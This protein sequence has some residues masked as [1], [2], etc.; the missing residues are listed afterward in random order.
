M[1]K[2]MKI[3]NLSSASAVVMWLF[4]CIALGA[5]PIKVACVGN[6]VTFGAGIENVEERYPSQLQKLLGDGYQVRNFGHNGATLLNNGHRPYQSL[7]EFEEAI[8]FNADIVIIH[9]GLNDTDPRNWPFYRDEFVKNYIGLIDSFKFANPD[10]E[11][12][13]CRLTPIFPQHPRFKSSTRDWYWQIQDAIETVA[14]VRKVELVDLH[15]PLHRRPDLFP[16]A[17][18][19]SSEG[20]EIIAKTIYGVITKDYGG[21]KIADLFSSKMI[22]QRNQPIKFWGSANGGSIVSVSF[23]DKTEKV[24]ADY[25]G[26]WEVIFPARE[27]G[28]PY[29]VVIEN[30]GDKTVFEDVLVGD[31]WICSGQSNMEFKLSG[32]STADED[33]PSANFSRIRLLNLQPIAYTNND[34][35]DK[36]VLTQINKLEYFNPAEWQECTP[37]SAGSFS[38]VAYHFGKKIHENIDIPIG[39]ILN[40]V[41]GSPAESWIDRKTLEH[42]DRLADMFLKWSDNDFI[43]GWVRHR[44]NTNIQLTDDKMQ[45]HPYHPSYLFEAGTD[46]LSKLPVAGVIWYQGESNEQNVELHEVLFPVLV[47]SWRKAW[48]IDLPF[49]YVQ[50]SSMAVGRES[51]G[52]FRDSQR[53]LMSAV[54]NSAMAVSSDLGDSTDVHPRRKKE[55]GERLALQALYK[56]Y[57]MKTVVPSGPIFKEAVFD[58]DVAV[59]SFDW[60]SGLTTSDSTTLRSF[61]IA[62]YPGLFFPANA[63]IV[64]DRVKVSSPK[65]KNPKYVRYGWSSYSDGNLVNKAG[66]PASTFSTYSN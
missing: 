41:G 6:S 48:N 21:L 13:I 27:A 3:V 10:A 29:R 30:E 52:H 22:L 65:V 59:L 35:W 63:E 60:E 11:I 42:H 36:E 44:A 33:I 38:A 61:E 51:W 43:N 26:R 20:A 9:L 39:L 45:R 62:E 12:K 57:G 46:Q 14:T 25:S 49:Y 50:L 5:T 37:E 19:P 64:D 28:G 32:A 31:I 24:A 53:K 16:D 17:L 1:S 58:Q 4:F 34:G 56:T 15:T 54:P 66:L 2:I 18:H 23:N 40:A 8:S 47:E 55:I 7:P